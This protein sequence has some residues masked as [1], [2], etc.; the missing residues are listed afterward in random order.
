MNYFKTPPEAYSEPYQ[1][2][3]YQTSKTEHFAKIV[4]GFK[5]LIIFAKCFMLDEVLATHV[6]YG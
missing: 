6:T 3:N 4:S 1:T 2:S 5:P